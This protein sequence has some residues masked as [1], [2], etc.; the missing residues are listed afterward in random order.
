MGHRAEFWTFVSD[1]VVALSTVVTGVGILIWQAVSDPANLEPVTAAILGLLCLLA[2]SEMVESRKR[3]DRIQDTIDEEM[4]KIVA[5]LPVA[6][7]RRFPDSAS[8]IAYL[9]RRMGEAK[10]S[11]DLAAI[12][13]SVRT[14]AKQAR[15]TFLQVRSNVVA[16]GTVR[17][18]YLFRPN[19]GRI[20][21]L[22]DLLSKSIPGK[23]FVASLPYHIESI[24]QPPFY[25]FDG[26]E[27][28]ARSPYEVGKEEVYVSVRHPDVVSFFSQWFDHLW[29]LSVKIDPK[30]PY[31]EQIKELDRPL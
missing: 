15:D 7:I 26:E 22:E 24:P 30:L 21:R 23:F 5:Y 19:Q 16:E 4:A 2:T 25:I 11:I 29:T 27:V 3:L 17:F 12:D 1:N 10:T 6:E 14:P 31:E 20:N 9:C 18:R 13:V 28:C 8:S